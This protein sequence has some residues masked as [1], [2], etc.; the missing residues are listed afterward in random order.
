MTWEWSFSGHLIRN[1]R[2]WSYSDQKS[3]FWSL[4]TR[5]NHIWYFQLLPDVTSDLKLPV[6]TSSKIYW[7]WLDVTNSLDFS[8]CYVTSTG[9]SN[10]VVE[11]ESKIEFQSISDVKMTI[12]VKVT[13]YSNILTVD[14][15][16]YVSYIRMYIV[17]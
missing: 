4:F 15:S 8:G 9:F 16:M 2:K 3:I 6:E 7:K 12:L 1:D 5:K 11:V 17:L 10:L 14:L 13:V